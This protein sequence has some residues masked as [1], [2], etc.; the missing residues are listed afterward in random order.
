M[1]FMKFVAIFVH[2]SRIV[3]T[4]MNFIQNVNRIVNNIGG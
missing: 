4:W 3:N 1:F 2:L